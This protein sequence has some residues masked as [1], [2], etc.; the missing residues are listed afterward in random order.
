MFKTPSRKATYNLMWFKGSGPLGTM[1]S[2]TCHP[3][4]YQSSRLFGEIKLLF[5]QRS[6]PT[7]S[8]IAETAFLSRG[9]KASVTK[10]SHTFNLWGLRGYNN[11]SMVGEWLT[12][13]SQTPVIILAS[14]DSWHG[15][16]APE[17]TCSWAQEPQFTTTY[18]PDSHNRPIASLGT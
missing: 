15:I 11:V 1:C 18:R 4:A 13:R 8:Q 5:S 14:L 16:R 12:S 6:W 7:H 9:K 10:K 2:S 3:A 17:C